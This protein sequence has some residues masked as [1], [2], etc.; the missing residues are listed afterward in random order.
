MVAKRVPVGKSTY[1]KK[2]WKIV[3]KKYSRLV[4]YI[5]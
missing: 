4:K 2:L 3:D 5:I 1:K